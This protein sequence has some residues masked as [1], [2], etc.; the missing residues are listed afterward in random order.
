MVYKFLNKKPA[1]SGV[2][3]HAYKS[4]FNNEKFAEELHKSINNNI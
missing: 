4:V 1:G 2:N 3:M